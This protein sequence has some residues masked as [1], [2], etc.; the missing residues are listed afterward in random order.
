MTIR[1]VFGQTL[2]IMEYT[3]NACYY[4][5]TL[6]YSSAGY[7]NNDD[8]DAAFVGKT[9]SIRLMLSKQI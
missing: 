2:I 1:E 9:A 7:D 8:I 3:K 4:M 6:S 5:K